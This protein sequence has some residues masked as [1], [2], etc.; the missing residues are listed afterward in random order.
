MRIEL[1]RGLYGIAGPLGPGTA[2]ERRAETLRIAGALFD[3]GIRTV[4]LRDKHAT[5]RELVETARALLGR[6][7]AAGA[8]LIVNDRLD[9]ALAA[10]ADGVHLGQDD[11]PVSEARRVVAQALGEGAPFVIG[12]ST[13]DES[14]V[15]EACTLEVDYIGFGPVFETR[16]KAD[17][18]PRRG[19][20]LLKRAVELAGALPVVAIG[21][22]SFERLTAV[23]EAGAAMA[24]VISDVQAAADPVARARAIDQAFLRAG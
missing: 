7:H 1:G 24:A 22:V 9:V 18:L 10:G 3:A 8:R 13:H 2:G 19:T 21:G 17:A 5:G 6:A 16:T 4:Q 14:Q 23:L 11:L 20:A 12:L 15:A